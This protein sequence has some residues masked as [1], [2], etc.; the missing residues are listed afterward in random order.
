[1]VTLIFFAITVVKKSVVPGLQTE[2]TIFYDRRIGLVSGRS[3]PSD[4]AFALC[5]AHL[6]QKT[7]YQNHKTDSHP[8]ERAHIF[9]Y[10]TWHTQCIDQTKPLRSTRTLRSTKLMQSKCLCQTKRLHWLENPSQYKQP[11]KFTSATN[12]RIRQGV[13]TKAWTL[14]SLSLYSNLE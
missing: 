4:S 14:A 13:A 1:M 11:V 8:N 2:Q 5:R 10:W 7:V 6:R 12:H 3:Q 9:L